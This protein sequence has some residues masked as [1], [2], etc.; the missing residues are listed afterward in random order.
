[1]AAAWLIGTLDSTLK[2]GGTADQASAC[3]TF[4]SLALPE[5]IVSMCIKPHAVGGGENLLV[6][7]RVGP[8]EAVVAPGPY[9]LSQ[10]FAINV[11]Q[12]K[13]CYLTGA[14]AADFDPDPRLDGRWNDVLKP[15]RA[16]PKKDFGFRVILRVVEDVP[17]VEASAPQ[18]ESL[19]PPQPVPQT[20]EKKSSPPVVN[21][22]K[23]PQ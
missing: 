14:A 15:F 4:G 12:D 21:A 9:H 20:S 5:P 19:P 23:R 17:P 16:V 1:V 13:A 3:A 7:E 11:V 8:M 2:K 10:T 18:M 6:N 22:N